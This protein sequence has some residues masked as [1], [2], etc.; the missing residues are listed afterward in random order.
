MAEA[1]GDIVIRRVKK[2]VGGGHHGGAWKVA[3]ADFVTA[4]MAFFLV[5]WL[6]GYGTNQQKAAVSEYFK[7][8]S[9]A[10]GQALSPSPGAM[11]PGGASTA[12]IKMGG[13][14]QLPQGQGMEPLNKNGTEQL[15]IQKEDYDKQGGKGEDGEQ[16][17][18][19]QRQIE[20]QRLEA[21]RADLKEAIGKSQA[22]EPFKDQLLI[23]LSEEGLRIQ[24]VDEKNRPMF[25]MGS[26]TLK[27]YTAAILEELAGFVNAVPNRI[28]ISGHTDMTPYAAG[29]GYTNWELSAERAN[30]ARRALVEGG[31][32]DD[33][34]VRVVGLSSSVL[35]DK[36]N[37]FNPI[38][39]RIS[40]VVMS[41][42]AE[43]QVRHESSVAEP[44]PAE[45]ETD[46]TAAEHSD[47]AAAPAAQRGDARLKGD[48][49][50]AGFSVNQ[51]E[52]EATIT[53]RS[54]DPAPAVPASH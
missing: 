11:G 49:E 51:R 7:N 44:A 23:D 48:R 54:T 53:R 32:Q 40:I 36:Q 13:S 14:M 18:A 19:E 46:G 4:M 42:D 29:R 39:R 10:K 50:S 37:P 41:H 33:K 24:I 27:P 16:A 52:S 6:V 9:L 17:K 28:S 38:N 15:A 1:K 35:F 5:M 47:A 25:D 34:I 26:S 20:Q 22:L 2:V 21:L 30:A 31:L 12:L 3:Y 8:P 43:A 45:A